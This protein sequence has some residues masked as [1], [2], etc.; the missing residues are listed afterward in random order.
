MDKLFNKKSLKE[1][2]RSLRNDMTPAEAIFWNIIKNNQ[3][4]VKFRRQHS[5]GNFVADFYCAQ[6]KLVVEVDGG[7][8]EDIINKMN[9]ERR[10]D[11]LNE[12][13]LTV[14]RFLNEEIYQSEERVKEE[15]Q[16]AV[17]ELKNQLNL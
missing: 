8:H 2:R 9:D 11:Y 5:I 10:E 4:G 15:L 12:L 13:G 16:G 17:D 14:V 1:I 6:L 7:M 3:L